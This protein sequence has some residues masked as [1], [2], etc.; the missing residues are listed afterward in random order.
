MLGDGTE[1][2]VHSL[3]SCLE[4]GR[5]EWA[6]VNFGQ[7][8]GGFCLLGLWWIH[9]V[10]TKPVLWLVDKTHKVSLMLT[11]RHLRKRLVLQL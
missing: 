6:I 7:D 3:I 8:F 1:V 11:S 10:L 5:V 2:I 4:A 9:T